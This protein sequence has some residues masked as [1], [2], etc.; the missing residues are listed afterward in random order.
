[1]IVPK[2][3]NLFPEAVIISGFSVTRDVAVG[4]KVTSETVTAFDFVIGEPV[5][6]SVTG[7]VTGVVTGSAHSDEARPSQAIPVLHSSSVTTAL[8]PKKS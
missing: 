3:F 8:A 1:M 7:S 5:S 4:S 2:A 6:G